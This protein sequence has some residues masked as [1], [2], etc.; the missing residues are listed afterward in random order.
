MTDRDHHATLLTALDASPRALRH[1]PLNAR[2]KDRA[3]LPIPSLRRS[4]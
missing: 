2:N 4:L 1:E 3:R